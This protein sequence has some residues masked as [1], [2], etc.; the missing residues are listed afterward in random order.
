MKIFISTKILNGA[1][2]IPKNLLV[3]T[4]RANTTASAINADKALIFDRG[5]SAIGVTFELERAHKSPADAEIFALSHAAEIESLLPAELKFEI[6]Q[7]RRIFSLANCVLAEI[8]ISVNGAITLSKY[9]FK[10]KNAYY[11][12]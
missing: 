8:R 10:A 5:N 4:W 11:E 7:S 2:E 12:Q 1:E 9:E 6:S 3:R